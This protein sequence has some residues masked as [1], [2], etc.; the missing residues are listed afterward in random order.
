MRDFDKK[1]NIIDEP[2]PSNVPLSAKFRKYVKKNRAKGSEI[3]LIQ[4]LRD[5]FQEFCILCHARTYANYIR[6]NNRSFES[7]QRWIGR[8]I[9]RWGNNILWSIFQCHF[10][11]HL[12]ETNQN[13]LVNQKTKEELNDVIVKIS[14][15]NHDLQTNQEFLPFIVDGKC[16]ALCPSPTYC[17]FRLKM[18]TTM[19]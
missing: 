5:R 19:K 9:R 13:S 1:N 15:L 10:N 17:W 8:T 16:N 6:E 2:T 3:I 11:L 4:K 12:S 14:Q 7:L 18:T